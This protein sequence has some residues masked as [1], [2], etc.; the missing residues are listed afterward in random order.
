MGSVKKNG[1][2]SPA[3]RPAWSMSPAIF[4]IGKPPRS[5][6]TV[7]TSLNCP[8]ISFML[9]SRV[10]HLSAT[11]RQTCK[12]AA[13]DARLT[14][15]HW[16]IRYGRGHYL[17]RDPSRPGLPQEKRRSLDFYLRVQVFQ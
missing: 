4:M 14:C 10:A 16:H 8:L 15:H 7:R 17:R 6:D 11:T 12:I 9:P 5:S 3:V 13:K 2:S 1:S